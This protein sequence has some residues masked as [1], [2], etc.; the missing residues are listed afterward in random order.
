MNHPQTILHPLFRGTLSSMKLVPGAKRLGTAALEKQE[1]T[2]KLSK[3][4]RL[5]PGS[6]APTESFLLPAATFSLLSSPPQAHTASD[7]PCHLEDST[8]NLGSQFPFNSTGR[9]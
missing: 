6:P 9:C 1:R 3:E 8:L 5:P 2:T 4:H 7:S